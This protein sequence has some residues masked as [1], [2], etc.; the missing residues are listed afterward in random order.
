MAENTKQQV[1]E[2]N[3]WWKQRTVTLVWKRGV[4]PE[5]FRKFEVG[6]FQKYATP[7]AD[8]LKQTSIQCTYLLHRWVR[9]NEQKQWSQTCGRA[10]LC[11][12]SSGVFIVTTEVLN[13]KIW[14]NPNFRNPIYVCTTL[15]PCG[16]EL[17]V[18]CKVQFAVAEP[19]HELTCAHSLDR[20][21]RRSHRTASC[22]T[23]G[24]GLWTPGPAR[25][26]L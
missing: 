10:N 9:R 22:A 14:L 20:A 25:E 26:A 13:P 8:I 1:V 21:V 2:N 15:K 7:Q 4:L 24:S 12:N 3:L 11:Q 6:P 19:E 5:S 17:P 16:K 18:P 23:L